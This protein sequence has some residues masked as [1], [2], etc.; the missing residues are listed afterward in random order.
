MS[1]DF[2]DCS[3]CGESVCECGDYAS[4]CHCNRKFCIDC[5]VKPYE[6]DE[7]GEMSK[8][9]CPYCSGA[10]VHN[11]DLLR[12]LLVYYGLSIDQAKDKYKAAMEASKIARECDEPE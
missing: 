12:F 10:E 5:L 2:F 3:V 1:V 6:S 8:E 9:C 4:C 7:D 11:D